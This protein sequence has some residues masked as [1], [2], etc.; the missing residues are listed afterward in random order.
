M[1]RADVVTVRV[2]DEELAGMQF[3]DLKRFATSVGIGFNEL[4]RDQ[5]LER[6]AQEGT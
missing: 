1:T 4:D 5:L 6:L 3:I 2:T